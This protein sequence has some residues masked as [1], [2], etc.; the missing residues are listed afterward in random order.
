M[1]R[2]CFGDRYPSAGCCYYEET[3]LVECSRKYDK[4]GK[5]IPYRGLLDK[6][7]PPPVTEGVEVQSGD[8]KP[9]VEKSGKPTLIL[10]WTKWFDI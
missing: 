9:I 5:Q 7:I 10:F 8:W 2:T 1:L 6:R 3:L 4:P